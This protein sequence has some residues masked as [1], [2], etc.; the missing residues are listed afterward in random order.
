M[1]E[2]GPDWVN[3]RS[4]QVFQWVNQVITLHFNIPAPAK[5][6]FNYHEEQDYECLDQ[7]ER[8]ALSGQRDA[9]NE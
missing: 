2:G 9:K 5:R 4:L 1:R 6:N 8:C 3:Q 7:M